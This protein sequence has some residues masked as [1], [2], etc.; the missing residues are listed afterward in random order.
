MEVCAAK[1]STYLGALGEEE[2]EEY[3]FAEYRLIICSS[4]LTKLSAQFA[5]EQI[6]DNNRAATDSQPRVTY[7]AR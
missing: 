7:V 2:A 5:R 4:G 3:V 6:G 1:R